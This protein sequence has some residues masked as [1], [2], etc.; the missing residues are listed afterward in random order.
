MRTNDDLYKRRSGFKYLKAQKNLL[1][2]LKEKRMIN[3]FEYIVYLSI[4]MISSLLPTTIRKFIYKTFL[5]E[6]ALKK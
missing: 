6:K 4:R 3:S 5:R 1:N 2:Y